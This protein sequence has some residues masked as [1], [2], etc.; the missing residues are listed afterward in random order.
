[1]DAFARAAFYDDESDSVII[2]TILGSLYVYTPDL[3]TLLRSTTNSFSLPYTDP[4]L[5]NRMKITSDQIGVKDD[6]ANDVHIYRVSDLSLV[7]TI[8]AS[9]SS[10]THNE[11]PYYYFCGF[12]PLWQA[13]FVT[14]VGSGVV[15]MLW[16]MPRISVEPIALSHVLEEECSFA[17]I[18][19]DAS[20]VPGRWCADLLP[21]RDNFVPDLDDRRGWCR[22]QCGAGPCLD[23]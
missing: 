14:G 22:A 8:D 11:L 23:H 19:A 17:G 9:D 5:S 3:G 16:Y 2:Q 1:M 13:V 12:D 21:A 20:A 15:S 7:Q 10:W 6:S 18:T 4:I